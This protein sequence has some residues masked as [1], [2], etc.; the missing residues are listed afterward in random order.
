[1]EF[2]QLLLEALAS[3]LGLV[4]MVISGI[5]LVAPCVLTSVVEG[6]EPSFLG[7]EIAL[8]TFRLKGEETL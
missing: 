7:E 5:L 6:L 4:D 2:L 1:M 3:V 8:R